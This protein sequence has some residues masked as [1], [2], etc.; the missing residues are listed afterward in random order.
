MLRVADDELELSDD[1][2]VMLYKGKPFSG[3]AYENYPDGSLRSEVEFKDGQASGITREFSPSGVLIG[4]K[5]TAINA[6]HGSVREWY[7]S[8]QRKTEGTYEYGICLWKKEWRETG[9]L[10]CDYVL[11]RSDP[12]YKILELRRNRTDAR[13]S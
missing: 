2:L 12:L 9:E 5:A 1:Y 6:Y 7:P 10:D 13:N 3:V 11:S 4:E 8:G